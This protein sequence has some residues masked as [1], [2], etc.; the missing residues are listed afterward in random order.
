[1]KK[2]STPFHSDTLDGITDHL[3]PEEVDPV[4][5]SLDEELDQILGDA[6]LVVPDRVVARMMWRVRV[7]VLAKKN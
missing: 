3:S 1:M 6:D 2:I 4:A 7:S 5:A